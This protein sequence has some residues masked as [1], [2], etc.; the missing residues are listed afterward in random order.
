[1]TTPPL[2]VRSGLTILVPVARELSYPTMKIVLLG[3]CQAPVVG[4]LLHL[5]A[6]GRVESRGIELLGEITDSDRSWVAEADIVFCQHG[7]KERNTDLIQAA[8]GRILRMPLVGARFLWPFAGKGH[9][10]NAETI[11]PW[12]FGGLYD[13]ALVDDQLL[14]LMHSRNVD[15]HSPE[16]LVDDLVEEYLALDYAK[17]V[18]L[19]RLLKRDHQMAGRVGGELG[20]R[21]WTVLERDF[22]SQFLLFNGSRPGARLMQMLGCELAAQIDVPIDPVEA[23]EAWFE[24][25]GGDEAPNNVAPVHPS[26][27]RHFGIEWAG[28]PARF[29]WF[30][31]GFLTMGEI[32][33]RAIR[34]APDAGSE[35]F[36]RTERAGSAGL[37]ALAD[38]LPQ[39]YSSPFFRLRYGSLLAKA[40]RGRDAA[41]QYVEAAR[42]LPRHAETVRSDIMRH[43]ARALANT[44]VLQG[45]PRIDYDTTIKFGSGEA[46][47]LTLAEGWYPPEKWGLWLRGFAARLHF[48][49]RPSPSGGGI[50]L[51]FRTAIHLDRT[52]TQAVRVFVNGREVALWW[53][54][55]SASTERTVEVGAWAYTADKVDVAFFVAQPTAP[56]E[57]GAKD[58]RVF[59]FGLTAL[60]VHPL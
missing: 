4:R 3:T 48:M 28:A 37:H 55:N 11:T 10:H 41:V 12:R 38:H 27:L 39:Y 59:G 17:L 16:T 51:Q 46:G 21:I 57:R 56:A 1:M 9:P 30:Y 24:M 54:E 45:P 31:D 33:K 6:H 36:H 13:G 18:D 32:I 52:G 53:F 58:T 25:Y 26:V 42:L 20:A 5:A 29:R 50:R 34:L 22:R 23:E 40:G 43:L 19:D 7:E 44:G 8:T 47:V 14:N 15:R 60:T 2:P 49:L 35:L